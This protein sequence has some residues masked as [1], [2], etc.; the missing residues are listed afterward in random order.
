MKCLSKGSSGSRCVKMLLRGKCARYRVSM[1]YCMVLVGIQY[2]MR[3]IVSF[4]VELV[5]RKEVDKVL[6]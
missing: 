1:A 6:L 4:G 5:Y 2:L 3:G